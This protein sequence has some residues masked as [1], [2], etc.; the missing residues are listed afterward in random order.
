MEEYLFGKGHRVNGLTNGEN[1]GFAA[2]APRVWGVGAL[3][4]AIA[5]ALSARFNPVAVRGEISGFT[6]AA[7]GHCYFTLKD[8]GGQLRCAMFRRA[9]A[10]LDFL[11][12]E[13]DLVEI[14]GR[15]AVYEPRGELQMVVESLRRAGQGNLFEQFVRLKARLEEEG[16][17]DAARKRACLLY[18][19]PSPRD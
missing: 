8:E 3:C 19:S 18:T 4:R 2:A 17:F 13:G 1:P 14:R 6:R 15:L 7:S 12:R 9:A 5:D 11:P 10:L 16:L